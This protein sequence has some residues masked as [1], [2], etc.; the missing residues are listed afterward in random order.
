MLIFRTAALLFAIGLSATACQKQEAPP[1][2][3]QDQTV[4]ADPR[5]VHREN[6]GKSVPDISFKDPDGGGIT[7][8]DFHGT[9]VLV[10]LWATWCAP[11]KKELPTLNALARTHDRDGALGVIAVS[12]D[13]APQGSVEAALA[14]MK[15]DDLGAYHDPKMALAGALGAEILPTTILYDAQGKEV[16]RY[17]GDLDW[18]GEEAA[19]LLAEA[20]A[21]KGR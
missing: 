12:Q 18:T 21:A 5:G 7:L 8:A 20:G 19:K 10:N 3:Q 9:P 4:A 17:V 2:E 15:V 16:W 13:M 1:N 14:D 6:A 11:C